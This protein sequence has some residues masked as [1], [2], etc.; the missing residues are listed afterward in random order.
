[1]G[2]QGT[3]EII[4]QQPLQHR[5]Q[6]PIT[7]LM[8]VKSKLFNGVLRC[9]FFSCSAKSPLGEPFHV[10][11]EVNKEGAHGQL[12]GT[13]FAYVCVYIVLVMMNERS[14]GIFWENL[15]TLKEKVLLSLWVGKINTM[16]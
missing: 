11:N 14:P 8:P 16:S 3:R 7:Q 9:S 12:G 2:I 6:P 15:V 5:G 4:E 10:L 1:M 13:C